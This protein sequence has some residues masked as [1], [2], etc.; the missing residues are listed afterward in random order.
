M[1]K[2][3]KS[4]EY[5]EL[6]KD[7]ILKYQ[8]K[9][10]SENKDKIKEY[11]KIYYENNK[12]KLSE[13]NKKYYKDHKSEASEYQKEY[14]SKNK[15][16]LSEY[17]KNRKKSFHARYSKLKSHVKEENRELDLTEEEFI[18]ITT[19]SCYYCNDNFRNPKEH[20]RGLDR[21]DN[22]KGYILNN[23][24]SCCK[25]CNSTR[26]MFLT[27]KQTKIGIDAVIEYRKSLN[28]TNE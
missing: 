2:Q 19:K 25:I 15:N 8:E 9:Y 6:N 3:N 21:I 17:S 10:R 1:E 24:L 12:H 20:G 7:K 26:G 4:T 16:K 18:Q 11:K 14:R 5:Y 22:S 23:V 13:K 28:K 27:V